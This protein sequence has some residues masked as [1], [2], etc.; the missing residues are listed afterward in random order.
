MHCRFICV[1]GSD[2]GAGKTVVASLVTRFLRAQGHAVAAFKPVCSGGRED[3][4]RLWEAAGKVLSLDQVNPWHF[5]AP[6]APALAAR[7][8][9]QRLEWH[10]LVDHIRRTSRGF[11]IV[12]VEGAGGLLSPMTERN[13]GRDLIAA[14]RASVLV[15]VPNRLGAVNQARL[16]LDALPATAVRRTVVVLTAP[17]LKDLATRTN[18]ALLSTFFPSE[19]ITQLP[20]LRQPFPQRIPLRLR[21][22]LR[23]LLEP[24]VPA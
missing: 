6:V 9:A 10:N 20:R 13:D 8:S 12:I 22:L 5:R 23:Q 14:L 24:I 11:K 15:V 2:T 19:R 21:K 4:V 1:T 17:P 7:E 18:A 16:V 3:A